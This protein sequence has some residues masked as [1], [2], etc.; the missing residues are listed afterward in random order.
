MI[1]L[2]ILE[3]SLWSDLH[4]ELYGAVRRAMEHAPFTYL[5][6]CCNMQYVGFLLCISF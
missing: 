3:G 4:G 5:L 2:T 1:V 6:V